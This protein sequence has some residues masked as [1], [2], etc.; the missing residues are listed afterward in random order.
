MAFSDMVIREAGSNKAS[1][2][3]C[4]NNLISSK[5]PLITPLFFVTPFI[6]NL[7]GHITELYITI[8][9]ENKAT[10]HVLNSVSGHIRF[11]P[12]GQDFEPEAVIDI[13][14]PIPS[15]SIMEPGKYVVKVLVNNEEM[16]E[17]P[18]VV[19]SATQAAAQIKEG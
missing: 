19:K 11:G 18:L 15:F 10:G 1:L 4:F 3:N 12:D 14:F 8:R 7:R 2:I 6:T 5:F 17:R 16:G 9:I 13:P